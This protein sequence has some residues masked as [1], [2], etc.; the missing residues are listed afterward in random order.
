[1]YN[2]SIVTFI[3]ILGFKEIV[4]NRDPEEVDKIL[5]ILNN[6]ASNE[7]D[8]DEAFD[9]CVLSLSDSIIRVRNLETEDNI[10]FPIGHL[11]LEVNT[12]VHAQMNLINNGVLVRGGISIGATKVANNRIFGPG[13]V[14][15]YELESKYANYPRI[16]LSPELINSVGDDVLVTNETHSAEEERKHLRTQL[17]QGD[18]AVWYIDYLRAAENELDEIGYYPELLMKHKELI[19]TEGRKH[20]TLSNVSLKYLWLAN[21]HNK[22]V[23]LKSKKYFRSYDHKKEDILISYD[24]MN[25]LTSM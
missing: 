21:Y 14:S 7:S 12:L 5:D 15:A 11:F 6:F 22:T 19:L 9:P 1:M 25:A 20:K 24:E 3:D 17:A 16:I 2:K 8:F 23:S 13:F 4:N 18:D 10:A